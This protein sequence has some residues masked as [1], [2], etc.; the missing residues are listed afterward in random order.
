MVVVDFELL[1]LEIVDV[2][3]LDGLV[4]LIFVLF[5]RRGLVFVFVLGFVIRVLIMG[6]WLV[7]VVFE[8]LVL[9]IIDV[10]G[11]NGLVGLIFVL[12]L[13]NGLVFV[14]VLGFFVGVLIMGFCLVLGVRFGGFWRMGR[15][16]VV[17]VVF[18]VG[19]VELLLDFFIFFLDGL[20]LDWRLDL[21]FLRFGS[22]ILCFFVFILIFFL[23]LFIIFLIL[24]L[25]FF[26][27]VLG[28]IDFMF[29]FFFK[30]F[31]LVWVVVL[32]LEFLGRR[33]FLIFCVIL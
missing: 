2:I 26:V 11:L 31:F 16:V 10:I 12:F 15:G 18:K 6:F 13:K 20:K 29:S 4:S 8:L 5:L 14:F 21:I 33:I 7:V 30:I 27:N 17:G 19:V 3:S 24:F 25:V 9:E 32:I 22:F 28:V 1:V 23:V